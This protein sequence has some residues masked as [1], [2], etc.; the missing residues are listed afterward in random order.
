LFE[1]K[2]SPSAYLKEN[3]RCNSGADI[4][5]EPDLLDIM[6]NKLAKTRFGHQHRWRNLALAVYRV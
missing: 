4:L 5:D 6:D 2:I 3:L 1:I